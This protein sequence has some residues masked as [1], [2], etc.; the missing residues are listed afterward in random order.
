M[1]RQ[2]DLF[3]KINHLSTQVRVLGGIVQNEGFVPSNEQIQEW[4]DYHNSV[5]NDLNKVKEDIVRFYQG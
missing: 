2:E 4:I 3:N 5:I 1:N